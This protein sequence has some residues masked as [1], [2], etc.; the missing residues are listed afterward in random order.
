IKE[1][2]LH[3][4]LK[5][6]KARIADLLYIAGRQQVISRIPLQDLQGRILGAVGKGVFSKVSK[7]AELSERI[8]HLNDQVKYYKQRVT[9][10]RGG[11]AIVG[12]TEAILRM[13]E[14]ALL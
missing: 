3:E 7:V 1:T 13:K 10:M 4:I 5:D 14:N 9:D 11:S 12:G 6:G 8:E 2:H